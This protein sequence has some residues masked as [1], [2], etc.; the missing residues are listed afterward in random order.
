MK[1]KKPNELGIYDMSGNVVEWC[2]E[3][4]LEY[5]AAKLI[6]PTTPSFNKSKVHR[7]GDYRDRSRHCRN[8]FR[9][10]FEPTFSV[11]SYGFRLVLDE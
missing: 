7:G 3:E 6:D 1:T 5:T 8:T 10:G 9:V 2:E 4:Y 11:T